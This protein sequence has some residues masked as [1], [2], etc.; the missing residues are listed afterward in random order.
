MGIRVLAKKNVKKA[1]KNLVKNNLAT[2]LLIDSW[3]NDD[4]KEQKETFEYLK[5]ALDSDRLSDRKLF[6]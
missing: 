1:D 4:E 5:K 3:L 2:V 6:K